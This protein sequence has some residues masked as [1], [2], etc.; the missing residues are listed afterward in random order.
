M[1]ILGVVRLALTLCSAESLGPSLTMTGYRAKR[2]Q[3][4]RAK[5]KKNPKRAPR[6]ATGT[7]ALYARLISGMAWF[8]ALNTSKTKQRKAT[9]R[10]NEITPEASPT[11]ALSI[12]LFIKA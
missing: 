4:G 11:P 9:E 2:S 8:M 6:I 3:L 7:A 10:K 12:N 5:V 1:H